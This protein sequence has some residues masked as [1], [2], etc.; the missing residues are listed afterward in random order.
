MASMWA[1]SQGVDPILWAKPAFCFD[2]PI[3]GGKQTENS[4]NI[5]LILTEM[6]RFVSDETKQR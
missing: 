4:S 5:H 1:I 6:M 2:S 3:S